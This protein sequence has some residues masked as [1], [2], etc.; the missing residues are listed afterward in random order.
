MTKTKVVDLDD[1]YNF[2]VDDLFI[3]NHLVPQN[4][5]RSSQILKFKFWIIKKLIWRNDQNKSYTSRWVAQLFCWQLFHLKSF[6]IPKFYLKFLYFKIQILNCSHNLE[7]R[8]NQN[9]SCRSRWDLK[10]YSWWLL[11]L[12]LFT[13]PKFYLKFFIFLHSNL[14]WR[15]KNKKYSI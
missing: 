3:W 9:K 5:I 11:H 10:T 2:V 14:A 12:K 8:N 4:S 7:R 6:V 1:F 13:I 15:E